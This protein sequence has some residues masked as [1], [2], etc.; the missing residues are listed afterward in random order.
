VALQELFQCFWAL[1]L[2]LRHLAHLLMHLKLQ[3]VLMRHWGSS[4][5]AK[6]C[7][8]VWVASTGQ[9]HYV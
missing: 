1:L 5:P 3:T 4:S 9:P 2:L 8:C 7:C 6:L